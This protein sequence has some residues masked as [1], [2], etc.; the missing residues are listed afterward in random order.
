MTKPMLI[1][2]EGNIATGKST[3]FEY[4]KTLGLPLYFVDEPVSDWLKIKDK[5]NINALQCFYQDQKRNSF[6]FQV[7]AYITRLK[8]LM[9]AIQEHPNSIIIS[10]RCIETDKYVFAKMLYEAEYI[11]SIEWETYNYWYNSFADISKVDLIIYIATEPEE[12]FKRIN[13]R[14]R[15]EESSISLDY[16]EQCHMKHEEWLNDTSIPIV[17]ING[18][19]SIEAIQLDIN[20]IMSNLV[21]TRSETIISSN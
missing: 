10:E 20:K 15:M 5:N 19:L 8:K 12:C 1:S 17:K 7:L 4:I 18:N 16:L 14:N 9:T 3:L 6:C 13:T 11:N 2:V 21:S